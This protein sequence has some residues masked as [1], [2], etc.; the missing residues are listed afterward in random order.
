M[1]TSTEPPAGEHPVVLFDGVC[2]L[3]NT[4]VRFLLRRDRRR[5]FRFAPLQSTAGRELLERHGLDPE[6]FDSV[7]LLEGGRPFLKSDAALRMVA[8]LPGLWPWLGGLRVV[9]RPLRD[10]LYDLV[11]RHRYRWFGRQEVCALPDPEERDRFLS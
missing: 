3:C 2:N 6:A 5:V 4:T 10:R 9:P 7:V 8:H 1:E 11:A